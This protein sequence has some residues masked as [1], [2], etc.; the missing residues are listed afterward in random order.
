MSQIDHLLPQCVDLVAFG[1]GYGNDRAAAAST[2][3]AAVP[4][5]RKSGLV[6]FYSDT[7]WKVDDRMG[8]GWRADLPAEFSVK[9]DALG[10]IGDNEVEEERTRAHTTIL[11]HRR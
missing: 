4:Q 8:T 1:H 9:A 7:I 6:Q 3:I 11:I 10:K 5:V 2:G